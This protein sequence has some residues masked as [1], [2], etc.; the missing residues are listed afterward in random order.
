MRSWLPALGVFII[1]GVAGRAVQ[2][3]AETAGNPS[4]RSGLN[5]HESQAGASLLGQFRTNASA[6]LWLKADLYLHNG[7][8]TRPMTDAEAA[9]GE[10]SIRDGDGWH[11]S[12]GDPSRLVTTV[13]DARRDFRGILGSLERETQAFRDL[14]GHTHREASESLP[15]FRLM[16]WLD[17]GFVP[18]WTTGAMILAG[19]PKGTDLAIRF[20]TEGLASNPQSIA[21]RVDLAR[22]H[23]AARGDA[24]TAIRILERGAALADADWKSLD[25]DDREAVVDCFRWLALALREAGRIEAAGEAAERGLAYSRNDPVLSRL[26]RP[27]A[28][29]W[30]T[31]SQ[32]EWYASNGIPPP[33]A[34]AV[35]DP[36]EAAK[37][38]PV[39][40]DSLTEDAPGHRHST[41]CDHGH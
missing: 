30:T 28:A 17:P 33:P 34:L 12:V 4:R 6:W 31:G 10:E 15:L 39:K 11:E 26:A 35:P 1:L 23:L 37:P 5:A 20:L 3:V 21:I 16:T 41:D 25:E 14:Q 13:P 27:P 36:K 32:L 24:R 22:L 8:E 18:G 19:E 38:Q 40:P 7:V 9:A 2:S 29:I